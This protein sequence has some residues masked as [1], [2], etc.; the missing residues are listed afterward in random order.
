MAKEIPVERE[1]TQE[2]DVSAFRTA[3]ERNITMT[4]SSDLEKKAVS[5]DDPNELIEILEQEDEDT[6][7]TKLYF[8]ILRNPRANADVLYA[9]ATKKTPYVAVVSV[10]KTIIHDPRVDE[11]TLIAIMEKEISLWRDA[12]D[13]PAATDA[14]R[15]KICEHITSKPSRMKK[16]RK[17]LEEFIR[18]PKT[19]KAGVELFLGENVPDRLK[20]AAQETLSA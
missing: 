7:D 2:T 4:P 20:K 5:S 13:S 8:L 1:T 16:S 6:S 15:T 11:R 14:L 19:P 18:D 10:L 3:L 12:I 17:Q 9:L